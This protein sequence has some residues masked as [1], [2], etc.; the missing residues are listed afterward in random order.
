MILKGGKKM[1][2]NIEEQVTIR[3]TQAQKEDLE[4]IGKELDRNISYL[5]REAI[6]M[7]LLEWRKTHADTVV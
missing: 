3:I 5:I 1:P 7:Y 4:K 2:D 6:T